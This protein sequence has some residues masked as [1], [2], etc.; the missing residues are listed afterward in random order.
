MRVR[1]RTETIPAVHPV[2][3]TA[4]G[5]PTIEPSCTTGT[6]AEPGTS[7]QILQR[8]PIGHC[9]I[10]A[11]AQSQPNSPCTNIYT[12]QT[13]YTSTL[14]VHIDTGQQRDYR[15]TGILYTSPVHG[16]TCHTGVMYTQDTYNTDTYMR[17]DRTQTGQRPVKR[18]KSIPHP[19]YS[20][21]A[22]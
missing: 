9:K 13:T 21:R 3:I 1:C 6:S 2:G 4:T 18:Y 8:P 12:R 10:Q 15:G 19:P 16:P 7:Q 11:I 20:Y 22:I 5:E 14:N 17:L